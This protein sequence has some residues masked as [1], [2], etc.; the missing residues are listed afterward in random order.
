MMNFCPKNALSV[1][2]IT[3]FLPLTAQAREGEFKFDFNRNA[4]PAVCAFPGVTMSLNTRIYGTGAYKGSRLGW[5]I[6]DSGNDSTLFKVVVNS[7]KEP[8]IL[9][10]A[11]YDPS[12]WHISWTK[13][14][15][16]AAVVVSGYHTQKVA[17]LPEGVPVLSST[18]EDKGPCGYT[19]YNSDSSRIISQLFGRDIEAGFPAEDG[20]AVVGESLP[21]D[22]ELLT[23]AESRIEDYR[24]PTKPLAGKAGLDE[25]ESQGLIRKATRE[26]YREWLKQYARG[27]NI[28]DDEIKEGIKNG[29]VRFEY[30]AR[31]AYVVLSPDFII[32]SGLSGSDYADFIVPEN[33]PLPEGPKWR[34]VLY[35]LKDGTCLGPH[36]GCIHRR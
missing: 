27:R 15:Q 30:P 4:D 6:G 10:L 28:P 24:D 23:N 9:A 16:I 2:L 36:P 18:Y 1:F 17:G 35:L 21:P 3:L 26:D 8:V 31:N 5:Q 20:Q 7:P 12:I 22:A 25:A 29:R 13:D 14:T 33:I 19:S 11:A 34:P 32:P